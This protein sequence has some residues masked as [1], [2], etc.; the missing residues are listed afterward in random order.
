MQI[1]FLGTGAVERVPDPWCRCSYCQE[2]RR[3][4]G[5]NVRLSSSLL[6]NDDLLI[7][8]GPDI[9]AA[10]GRLGCDLTLVQALLVTH[11]HDDHLDK[12]TL[13]ARHREWGGTPLPLLTVYGGWDSLSL[14]DN[15]DALRLRPHALAPF[16]HVQI[17]TGGWLAPDPRNPRYSGVPPLA[18]DL[19]QTASRRYE[20]FTLAARHGTAE[21]MLFVIQQV[22]GSE[23]NASAGHQALLYATDTGPFT[24][25]TWAFLDDL[26]RAGL[27]LA[28]TVLDATMGVGR[29]G[30]GSA[31]HLSLEEMIAHQHELEQ[32]HL[33]TD[34]CL[35]LA[36]HF[37]HYFTPPH[38]ELEALLA[39]HGIQ[40][41]YDGLTFQI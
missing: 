28:A 26:S 19:P 20:V 32:H 1:T 35:R 18:G 30:H 23:V 5:C 4:G 13:G 37:S 27:R 12:G 2:A 40:P 17:Q 25:R 38:E 36:H 9:A 11:P 16:E 31:E 15:W 39:P 34:D 22:E 3:R 41:V 7:D 10:A 29:E 14:I 33:L 6:I 21:P 24:E 8:A